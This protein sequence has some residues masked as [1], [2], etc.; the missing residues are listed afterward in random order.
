IGLAGAMIPLRPM[1]KRYDHPDYEP[2]WAA[3]Q[4]LAM[5]LSLHVGT[6][7]W[8]PGMQGSPTQDIVEFANREGDV[9]RA[10]A[11]FLVGGVFDAYARVEGGAG[12]FEIAWVP[13]FM[14]RMD[15][16]YTERAQGVQRRRFQHGALPSDFFRQNVFISFQEDALGIQLRSYVGVDNLLW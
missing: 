7:R 13:Y 16:V 4:D 6:Y 5:P 11:A 2:L 10:I 3:A 12:E 1:E 8:Q 9:R 14:N 15:N